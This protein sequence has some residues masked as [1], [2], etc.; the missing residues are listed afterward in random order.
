LKFRANIPPRWIQ[1]AKTSRKR[2]EPGLVLA[3]SALKR[4]RKKRPNARVA[5]ETAGKNLRAAL[6]HWETAYN[7]ESFYRGLRVLLALQRNGSSKI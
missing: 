2:L 1:N 7:K 5:I 6:N 3:F 4:L